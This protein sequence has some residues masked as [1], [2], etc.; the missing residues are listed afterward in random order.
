LAVDKRLGVIPVLN[1]EEVL[2]DKVMQLYGFLEQS[3]TDMHVVIADNASDDG[4][5]K[6]A[7]S[8]SRRLENVSYFH[9][10]ER[11]KWNAIKYTWLNPV[12]DD[13]S[14]Y[15]FMD[16]DMATDPEAIPRMFLEFEKG[17]DIVIGSRYLPESDSCRTR[18]RLKLSKGFIYIANAMFGL[19]LSDYQCG[20]KGVNSA[21]R[22]MVVP[23]CKDGRFFMDTELLVRAYENG[24]R[25]VQLPVRWRENEASSSVNYYKE[26]PAFL[27]DSL[28]FKY[29]QLRYGLAERRM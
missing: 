4:S 13:Y 28:R 20:F 2:E 22:N 5:A 6:I 26:V 14:A 25:I 11:G 18:G 9:V 8:L 3:G 23:S 21:V 27:L 17:A 19:G 29:E 15:C 16:T 24:Y 7:K 1:E 12:F 10:P